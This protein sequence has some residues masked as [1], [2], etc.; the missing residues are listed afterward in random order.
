M[1]RLPRRSAAIGLLTLLTTLLVGTTPSIAADAVSITTPYPAIAVAPGAKATF[2]INVTTS[3]TARVNL[4]VTGAPSTWTTSLVGGGFVVDGVQTEG[5]K[6]T[7]VRLDVT[8]SADATAGTTRLTV[9][10]TS[11]SGSD[12]LPIDI[13][14]S[15][16]AAGQVSLT[17]DLP[18]LKGPSTTQFSFN[19]TLKN[20]TSEDLTFVTQ[21][22]GP[23]GWTITTQLSSSSTAAS[24]LVKA[25][26][27]TTI[28]VTAKAASD[29]AAGQYQIGVD[30]TSG[31]YK[32]HQDLGVEL[33]GSYDLSLGTS[34]GRLNANAT[35]GS[36]SDITFVLTN[37][38]T[39]PITGVKL[40]ATPPSGWTVTYDPAQGVDVPAANNGVSGTANIT[41]HLTPSKDAIAGDYV[42]SFSATGNESGATANSDIRVTIQTSLLGGLL[43]IGAIVLVLVGLGWVFLRYGRR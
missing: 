9:T 35:A 21:G 41:A 29:A 17:T 15:P 42:T 20:D 1:G 3:A 19:L 37:S 23:D 12:S 26:D 25:G 6:P 34:D 16:A 43:G 8:V 36:A 30:A 7:T 11:P 22:T 31:T 18:S 39:A 28:S 10:A 24:A 40:S 32:A 13:R 4:A 5:T 2:D 14:V 27:S 33:T 38:G